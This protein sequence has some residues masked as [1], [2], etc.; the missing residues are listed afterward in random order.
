MGMTSFSFKIYITGETARSRQ[1]VANLRALFEARLAG[2]Y[3]LEVVD[4]LERPD[5]AE[6]DRI[7]AT[8]TVIRLAPPP[9]RRVVGDLSE[10]GATATA[11]DLPDSH[12]VPGT[13]GDTL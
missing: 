10:S 3:E 1:A 2:L 12:A 5:L 8:P 13:K 11:L 6:D 4:V 9:R 7:I